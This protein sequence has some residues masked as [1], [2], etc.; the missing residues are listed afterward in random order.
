[1]RILR[2]YDVQ[3]YYPSL[4]V[5]N[6]YTSRNIPSAEDFAEVYHTRLEAKRTGDKHTDK[7]LKL[8]LNT[9]YGASLASTNP[10]FDPLMG[11]SICISGQLYLLELA[12]N[13]YQ[14]IPEL[15][16]V[17]LNTDGIL[18]EFDDSNYTEVLEII[19]EWQERTGFV[20]EEDKI[21]SLFQRDVNNYIL[22][23]ENGK[24]KVKGGLTSG[25]PEGGAFKI[26]NDYVIVKQAVI[27]YFVNGTPARET[28]MGCDDI[29][30]FQLIAKA[31]GGYRSVYHV[32]PNFE[33]YKKNW[34]K[35]NRYR[36]EARR[37]WKSPPFLWEHYNGPRRLIQRVNR[38]YASQ[39]ASLGTIMKVK[40]DGTVGKIGGLP[41]HCVVDNKNSLTIDQID[42]EWYVG[43]AER[44][45]S[46]YLGGNDYVH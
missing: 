29:H 7:T 15:R 25:I 12:E 16:I 43:E 4:M 39:S 17:A 22:V 46:E 35:E 30:K 32:A 2:N 40:P 21:R 42:R 8:I 23:F 11:R 19:D 6:G 13:L 44:F 37:V 34:Q 9:T 31:G 41:D 27:D 10:L 36:D 45:I 5:R 38:V 1:M 26:N 33:A 28:I 24:V 3:S 14:T 18:I 20:L